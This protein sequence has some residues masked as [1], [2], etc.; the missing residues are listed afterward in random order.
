V[1]KPITIKPPAAPA[2]AQPPAKPA[3]K[4]PTAKPPTSKPEPKAAAGG[5]HAA[6]LAKRKPR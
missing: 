2:A 1:G 6:H 3:A 4:Q 5:Q